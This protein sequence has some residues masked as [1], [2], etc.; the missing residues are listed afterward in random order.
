MAH[1]QEDACGSNLQSFS[2]AGGHS[3]SLYTPR[4]KKKLPR[5]AEDC[6]IRAFRKGD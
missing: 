1:I 3:G 2:R 5:G 6:K 4:N